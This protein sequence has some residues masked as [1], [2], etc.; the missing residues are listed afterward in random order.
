MLVGS[1]IGIIA[2]AASS[3]IFMIINVEG[4][5][6]CTMGPCGPAPPCPSVI[7]QC[8]APQWPEHIANNLNDVIILFS[9]MAIILLIATFVIRRHLQRKDFYVVRYPG[10]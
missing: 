5:G 4:H 2:V 10:G 1:V 8:L 3:A 7:K 6:V 9:S